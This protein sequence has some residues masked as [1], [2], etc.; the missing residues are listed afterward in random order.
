MMT[1]ADKL[2][3]IQQVK[4]TGVGL[5]LRPQVATLPLPMLRHD[6]PFLPYSKTLIGALRDLVCVCMFDLAAYMALAAAGAVAL[7]RAIAYANAG[8]DVVTILHGPFASPA[9]VQAC[10]AEA[11]AVDGVTVIDAGLVAPYASGRGASGVF[12][13]G[14]R[15]VETVS[16]F[17]SE[18]NRLLVT[19]A[20]LAVTLIATDGLG[21]SRGDDF[22]E[23]A[24][25]ALI[26]RMRG[27]QGA[28]DD[29]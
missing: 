26:A 29:L 17:D 1:L 23:S 16:H 14:Q 2:T 10:S 19:G 28:P 5:L 9:F 24:R 8:D 7:E 12:V 25:A 6:D 4:G 20:S 27:V 18:H 21:S 11:F 15:Q 22:A 3:R 13:T